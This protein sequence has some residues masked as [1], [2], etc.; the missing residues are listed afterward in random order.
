[1]GSKRAD[2]VGVSGIGTQAGLG[3]EMVSLER[4]EPGGLAR[5]NCANVGRDGTTDGATTWPSMQSQLGPTRLH[6]AVV[7]RATVSEVLPPALSRSQR[8]NF[9]IGHG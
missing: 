2:G 3:P 8:L 1:M 7:P 9:L 4:I 5:M 6:R